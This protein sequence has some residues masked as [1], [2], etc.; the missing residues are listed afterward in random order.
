MQMGGVLTVCRH[1]VQLA[2]AWEDAGRAQPQ[3]G[4]LRSH[5]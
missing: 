1:D 2:L 3:A 4:V 5:R